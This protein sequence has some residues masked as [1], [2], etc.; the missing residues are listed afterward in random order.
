[1]HA[2]MHVD[3]TL[4]FVEV[5]QFQNAYLLHSGFSV[6]VEVSF[7][8][9]SNCSLLDCYD[10]LFVLITTTTPDSQTILQMGLDEG[11]VQ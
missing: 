2:I 3:K 9:S 7:T 11:V 10:S 1:M 4:L 8:H 5:F 6:G